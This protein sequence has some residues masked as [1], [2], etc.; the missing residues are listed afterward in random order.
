[1]NILSP[2]LTATDIIHSLEKKSGLIKG[3]E[4]EGSTVWMYL[5]PNI[6]HAYQLP[7]WIRLI[8]DHHY[9]LDKELEVVA[10]AEIAVFKQYLD[11]IPHRQK[12]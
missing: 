12:K 10:Y 11:Q 1:M 8:D 2:E 3:L 9:G 7:H 6:L 5:H 4:Q